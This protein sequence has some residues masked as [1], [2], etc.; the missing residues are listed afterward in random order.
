MTRRLV[1]K[2]ADPGVTKNLC[3][4]PGRYTTYGRMKRSQGGVTAAHAVMLL[5][6]HRAISV[7]RPRGSGRAKSRIEPVGHVAAPAYCRKE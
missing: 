2:S 6:T 4:S 5:Q 3:R 1:S 7:A